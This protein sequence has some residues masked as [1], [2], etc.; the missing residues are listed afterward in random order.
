[1]ANCDVC[2]KH[3]N[4]PYNC[5]HCGGTYCSEHRLPE[6]HNCPGLES[7]NDPQNVFDSGFDDS[8]NDSG[9]T[10]SSALGKL[11]LDTGAGGPLGYFRNNVSYLFL[12]IIVVVFAL[13]L[14][15][16]AIQPR[17]HQSIFTLTTAHPEYVWT[18][19]ISVFSHSPVNPT[20]ILFNGIVLYFFGPI[21]ER[22][23]G[24]KKFTILFLVS[25]MAAGLGQ[26]GVGLLTSEQVAVLGASG[27]LMALLGVLAMTSPDL[28]V[29]LFFF[30]P[31]S[32]RTLAFLY[33]IGSVVFFVADG[34][35]LS[36]VAHFAHLTGLVI[37]LWYGNRIKHEV[38]RGPGQLNIGPGRGGGGLR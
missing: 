28:K 11:G 21:V 19:V 36:G 37:G 14:A 3:V 16:I 7:W 6:N 22:Q 1:M 10:A 29:L 27:A 31:V 26:V 5:R 34:G 12:G 15:V 33:A 35:P 25:G 8:V 20:H 9:G 2:G 32:M 4:M 23:I 18:W 30:I 17:L 38:G 13:Q 24:S